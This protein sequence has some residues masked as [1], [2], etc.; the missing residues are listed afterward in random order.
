MSSR[1]MWS[2]D[3]KATIFL[4]MVG[5]GVY[6]TALVAIAITAITRKNKINSFRNFICGLALPNCSK[7]V[8]YIRS[9]Q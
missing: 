9:K 6:C 7:Q 1:L 2:A 3:S 5:K 8:P 4:S